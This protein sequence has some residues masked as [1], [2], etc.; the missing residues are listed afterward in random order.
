MK[1]L[2]ES[3]TAI[4]ESL[5]ARVSSLE[6]DSEGG[7]YEPGRDCQDQISHLREL[8]ESVPADA[9][10]PAYSASPEAK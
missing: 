9:S 1:A 5:N 10:D 2:L 8:I 4:F 6:V 3:I 7:N